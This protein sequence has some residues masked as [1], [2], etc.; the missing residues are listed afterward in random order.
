M[1]SE[2]HNAPCAATILTTTSSPNPIHRQLFCNQHHTHSQHN[3]QTV[4]DLQTGGYP[5]LGHRDS[6]SLLHNCGVSYHHHGC[7][8]SHAGICISCCH[9]HL[10]NLGPYYGRHCDQSHPQSVST[11]DTDVV[12]HMLTLILAAKAALL[13][14]SNPVAWLS[15]HLPIRELFHPR[16]TTL[17][18][19]ISSSMPTTTTLLKQ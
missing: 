2:N 12:F 1:S 17:P 13:R 11:A 4:L 10:F 9:L 14:L 6:A 3:A 5:C 18:S 16:Q 7:R 15:H 8:P 19:S